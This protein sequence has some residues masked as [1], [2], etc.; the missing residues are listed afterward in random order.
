MHVTGVSLDEESLSLTVSETSQLTAEVLPSDATD[1]SVTWDSSDTDVATVDEN[2]LVTAV[3]PG[4]ATVTVMTNDGGFTDTCEVT[5]KIHIHTYISNVTVVPTCTT[6]GVMTYTCTECGDSY[7]EI[8]P[9]IGHDWGDWISDGNETSH[10]RVCANDESH[11]ETEACTWVETDRQEPTSSED[12]WID[13]ECSVCGQTK[14]VVIP[15]ISTEVLWASHGKIESSAT[16]Q[17]FVDDDDFIFIIAKK[18]DGNGPVKVQLRRDGSSYLTCTFIRTQAD[19]EDVQL[20]G[21]PCELWRIEKG[22]IEDGTYIAIAK[23]IMSQPINDIDNDT[24]YEFVIDTYVEPV[25]DGRV[26]D[27]V[28]EGLD[29]NN[30]IEYTTGGQVMKFY[31]AL[32]VYKIQLLDKATLGTITFTESSAGVSVVVGNYDGADC[33][34]WT[35]NKAFGIGSY[36]FTVNARSPLGMLDSGHELVFRVRPAT[37]TPSENAFVS[38][39]I[40][41][42]EIILGDQS[43]ITVIT[44]KTATKVQ[45]V[46]IDDGAPVSMTLTKD[47]NGVAWTDNGDTAIWT[48]TK[49]FVK[50]GTTTWGIRVLDNGVYTPVYEDKIVYTV[51]RPQI[52]KFVS[53]SIDDNSLP[54]AAGTESTIT[55]VTHFSATKVQ[56]IDSATGATWTHSTTSAAVKDIIIDSASG[57]A[58]WI[59]KNKFAVGVYDFNVKV[60]ADGSYSDIVENALHFEVVRP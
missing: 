46:G 9:S 42:D 57:T 7:T 31:T 26:F 37:V 22:K 21:V 3:A 55:V 35:I 8:I 23:Y 32:D 29:D 40:D 16:G 48:I 33:L 25:F 36:A 44:C 20:Y 38:A 30:S 28:I 1:K 53:V 11:T 13:Y 6:P 52:D 49:T 12:G 50:L 39:E 15:R 47:S 60:L 19:I 2:G 59:I 56:F 27:A 41:S 10:T 45:F 51:S 18:M 14:H 54:I 17:S 4:T 43:V 5:V 34:V 24:G 58:T